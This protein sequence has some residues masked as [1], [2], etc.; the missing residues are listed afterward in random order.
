M[1]VRHF[2]LWSPS[3]HAAL[4]VLRQHYPL[5]CYTS[6]LVVK[7]KHFVTSPAPA[8]NQV[9][10]Q[11]CAAGPDAARLVEY[12]EHCRNTGGHYYTKSVQGQVTVVAL[13]PVEV[14]PHV[15]STT[16]VRHMCPYEQQQ[17]YVLQPR[18]LHGRLRCVLR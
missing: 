13:A 6:H 4:E 3:Y 1:V 2:D 7:A 8:S 12:F 16:V 11:T 15:V 5:R 9:A 10:A 14:V 18:L 17:T